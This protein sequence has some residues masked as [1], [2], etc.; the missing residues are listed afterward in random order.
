MKLE[1]LLSR[2]ETV[3]VS[4]NTD[5]EITGIAYDSRKVR[6]GNLFVCIKGYQSDG[7]LY[8]KSAVERGAAAILCQENVRDPGV[9]VV[10]VENSRRALGLLSAEWYGNPA[11]KMRM[12]GITGTNGKTTCTYL[13]K[14]IL[15]NCG[16]KV[17]LIGTNQNMIGG[18]VLKTERTTPESLELN[19][20]L[21]EMAEKGCN[22]VVMEVSSHSLYL[23]RVAG[24]HYNVGILT[25]ITQDHLDFHKTMEEYAKAKALLFERCDTAVLNRD[26]AYYDL[27]AS[28]A[29]KVL[30]YGID[31]DCD[32]RA[33]EIEINRNGVT[34][35]VTTAEESY[36][37]LLPIPGR[38]SVYNALAAIGAGMACGIPSGFMKL[39]LKNQKGVKGRLEVLNTGTDY[40]VIIDYAHAPDGLYNVLST[41]NEFKENRVITVFGCG[42]DRDK[43]KRPIMGRIAGEHSDYLIVTSDNPRTEDPLAILE[44]I[45]VGV[46]ETG[47]PYEVIENR[48]DAIRH[49]MDIAQPGDIILLAGKGHETYQ[50]LRDRTIHLDEREVVAEYLRQNSMSGRK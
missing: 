6:P 47:C 28:K 45:A 48:P 2:I 25:N 29:G 12:I 35:R 50:I 37:A 31:S 5:V 41:I 18:E 16:Y 40:T 30:S 26:D 43:T 17:G 42:G 21:A 27:M 46:K 38:F 11:G 7:H 44:D 24:I 9:P 23:D 13:I 14:G 36:L 1:D 3:S 49:A 34:F 8:T 32:L 15:E 10:K 22:Y 33:S 19:G 4:G 20:L 39:A